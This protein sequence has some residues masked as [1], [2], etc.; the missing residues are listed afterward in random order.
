MSYKKPRTA[1]TTIRVNETDLA[2]W[3]KTAKL[4]SMNRNGWII[5]TL[6]AASQ[7]DQQNYLVKE[8]RKLTRKG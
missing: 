5:Q 7:I 6:N 8:S 3:T 1:T 4:Q 2:N